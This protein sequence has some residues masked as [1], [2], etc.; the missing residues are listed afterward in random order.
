MLVDV[1]EDH[2]IACAYQMDNDDFP[3]GY[4]FVSKA[5]LREI[6][7][8]E[9]EMTGEKMSVSGVDEV[10]KGFKICKYCGKIQP[11]NGKANHTLSCKVRKATSLIR[12]EDY[13]ECL[14]LYREFNTE[15]LRLLVPA[16][17]MDSTSVK[18]ESFVAAFMLGMK[19][20]FGNVDHL[21]AT[22]SEVPV[23]G[24]DYRK[25]Y[26]VIYD[27]V[28]G[29]TGYLKQLMKEKDSLIKI[30]EKALQK[31]E[32]CSCKDDPQKD[33]CYH[34]LYAYR[35]SQQ[36]G[37]I[38]RSTAMR[39]LKSILSGKKNIKKISKINEIQVNP[40]FDSELEQRFI[41]AIR[42]KVGTAN[43]SDSIRNGKHC[44]YIKLDQQA[45]EIE[46]QVLLE[47]KDGVGV[48]CKPDF[49]IWPV[50]APEHK[51]VAIFTDGFLYHKDIVTDD[52]IKR[53]AIRRSGKYRVW[54][55]SYK[56]VQ[57]V[58]TP[59][60]DFATLTLQS[61]MMPSGKIM[62]QNTVKQMDSGSIEPEK[63]SSFDLL[64][65]YL[66]LPNAEQLFKG[67]AYAYSLSLL[68]PT[69]INNNAT[70]N[71]WKN[72]IDQVN[73]QAQFTENS[74]TFQKT[75]YGNWQPRSSNSNLSIYAGVLMPEVKQQDKVAVVAALEDESD[76][77]TSKYESEW[78]G[79]WQ[80]FNLMQFNK[81]FIAIATTGIERGDY[82]E[83]PLIAN[84]E[85]IEDDM[86]NETSAWDKIKELLFDDDSKAFVEIAK[87]SNI[88]VP[89]EENIGYE[90]VG[91]DQEVIATIEIAWPDKKI[92][93]MTT[94]QLEDKA[95]LEAN[96][97]KVI[98]LLDAAN[99]NTLFG[100]E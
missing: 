1:D 97:W 37:N 26:L 100:G 8:G 77:R 73:E 98:N 32:N 67:Q 54:A 89:N 99:I 24:A 34:C 39:L 22:V 21:R 53:E 56:D 61:E 51:P 57:S 80:F 92:G 79:L 2:D 41:E 23:P 36:I 81:E 68:E 74:F 12:E 11:E 29:G 42:Q 49:M 25:Q 33:G 58:F 95:M 5:T 47:A 70:F 83:L 87:T 69:L 40:L 10:R 55:L 9:S 78:N 48:K 45:W 52:T 14:F 84:E 13:E 88:P 91:N 38:S 31:M 35:Q 17:T 72:I 19:E 15:I 16:T 65:A 76:K 18:M 7:F 50:T 59:Q 28:P 64:I 27:S 93:F 85:S 62:Y 75:F 60:G 96:G 20:Y 90:V 4:E 43:V 63:M 6:N 82:H 30:F 71:E 86:Q 3:F 66:K 46:P 94:E 44:Y